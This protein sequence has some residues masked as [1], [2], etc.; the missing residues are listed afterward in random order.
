VLKGLSLGTIT[1]E[2]PSF[3]LTSAALVIKVSEYP[4]EIAAIV[5]ILAGEMIIPDTLYEPLAGFAHSS[6]FS[7]TFKRCSLS[8]RFKYLRSVFLIS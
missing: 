2:F 1:S 3:K 6:L 8:Q 4:L 5:D 7:Q